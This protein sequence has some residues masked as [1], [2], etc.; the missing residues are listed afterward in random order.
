MLHKMLMAAEKVTPEPVLRY[1]G[2]NL[3]G[4]VLSDDMGNYDATAVGVTTSMQPSG[5]ALDFGGV[6]E[7]DIDDDT[8]LDNA[9]VFTAVFDVK[10]DSGAADSEFFQK[11]AHTSGEPLVFWFDNFAS[12]DRLSFIVTDSSGNTSSTTNTISAPPIGVETNI[13]FLFVGGQYVRIFIDGVE[14]GNSPFLI[15]DVANIGTSTTSSDKKVRI[16]YNRLV[17]STNKH[18]NGTINNFELY[19]E[20]V[21]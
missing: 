1:T 4:S 15:P 11:G 21:Y 19:L 6:G 17:S 8:L 3:S 13:R 14:D 9:T 2:S 20:E 16:G 7:V 18:L 10:L 12:G 5:L